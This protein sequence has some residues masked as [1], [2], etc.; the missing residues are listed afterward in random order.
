MTV[1]P[2][3]EKMV[4]EVDPSAEDGG[5]GLVEAVFGPRWKRKLPVAILTS[6][7]T[8]YLV[9]TVY[10]RTHDLGLAFGAGVLCPLVVYTIFREWL[11]ETSQFTKTSWARC[12]P[13]T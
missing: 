2:V 5:S 10:L 1:P 4:D 3:R 13:T 12:R 8:A 6:A 7:P 11:D 9:T